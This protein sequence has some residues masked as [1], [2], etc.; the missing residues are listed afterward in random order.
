MPL[1]KNIE[2]LD[3]GLHLCTSTN[4]DKVV[5]NGKKRSYHIGNRF[6]FQISGFMSFKS[7]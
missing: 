7:W 5:V 3:H 4:Y 1:Y 2:T 6:K